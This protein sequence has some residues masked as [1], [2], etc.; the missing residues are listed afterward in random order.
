MTLAYIFPLYA[1]GLSNKYFVHLQ[2]TIT[3]EYRFLIQESQA[4]LQENIMFKGHP[5]GLPVLFFT[6]MWERFGFYLMLGI[7][8]LYMTDTARGGLGFDNVKA[9][10][11]V[12]T[13]LA[14][15]YLTPFGRFVGGPDFG[16][17]QIYYH[18]R[19]PDGNR[20]PDDEHSRRGGPVAG[21]LFD[22]FRERIF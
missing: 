18:R 17:P 6:E 21:A 19:G 15:V 5:R 7:F 14:L 3:L 10:D 12:G 2:Q 16:I 22:Y 8:Y 1:E 20:L 11:I 13:Y 9:T 4:N